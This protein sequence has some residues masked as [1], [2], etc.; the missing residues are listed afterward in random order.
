MSGPCPPKGRRDR[1]RRD[2]ADATEP[3]ATEPDGSTL[4]VGAVHGGGPTHSGT[5]H[6]TA[7][8]R[9]TGQ[10]AFLRARFFGAAA[11]TASASRCCARYRPV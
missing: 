10:L 5:L 11:A 4:P 7:F 9:L 6:G 8:R 1:R 3:D 2:R